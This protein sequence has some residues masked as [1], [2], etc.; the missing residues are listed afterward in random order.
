MY[1]HVT[2]YT[3]VYQQKLHIEIT[4]TFLLAVAYV[5]GLDILGT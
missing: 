1:V 2:L 4:S 5:T 3:E